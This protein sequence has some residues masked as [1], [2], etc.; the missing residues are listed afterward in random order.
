M[1]AQKRRSFGRIRINQRSAPIRAG[2]W[3]CDSHGISLLHYT[4][5]LPY[6][7]PLYDIVRSVAEPVNGFGFTPLAGV[8]ATRCSM[9]PPIHV[10]SETCMSVPFFFHVIRLH[11]HE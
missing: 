1:R 9:L 8:L 6:T 3:A 5:T 7:V 2:E 11:A 10:G 4:V